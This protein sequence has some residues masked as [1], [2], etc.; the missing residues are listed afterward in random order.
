MECPECGGVV[1]YDEIRGEYVCSQCGL[2]VEDHVVQE[3]FERRAFTPEEKLRRARVGAPTTMRLADKGLH[4][5]V[6]VGMYDAQRVR[7]PESVRVKMARLRRVSRRAINIRR[8]LV[9]ALLEVERIAT[10]FNTG[11]GVKE[12]ACIL[13][14]KSIERKLVLGY[15]LDAVAASCVYIAMRIYGH[16][17]TLDDVARV[18]RCT[19]KDIARCMRLVLNGLRIRLPPLTPERLVRSIVSKLNM[20]PRVEELAVEI[21]RKARELRI[22]SGKDPLG[23]AAAAV[24]I[25]GILLGE[26]RTQ[27]EVAHCAGV[28]EITVRNRY[29]EMIENLDMRI[30][31]Q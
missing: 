12:T 19:R 24:Y 20:S 13:L 28:A 5:D 14:R 21:I 1:V 3:G 8:S 23:V 15:P 2:V 17:A 29:R 11:E 9:R 7:L 27:R 6:P 10:L 16:V 18:S 31:A 26:R 25:S 30:E 4:T 22:C